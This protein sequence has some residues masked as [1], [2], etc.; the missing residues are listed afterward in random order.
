LS[1][2]GKSQKMD[3]WWRKHFDLLAEC[4]MN[5]KVIEDIVNKN[6]ARFR[7]GVLDFLDFLYNE[8]IPLI[9]MSAGPGQL[10]EKVLEKEGRLYNNIHIIANH[11]IFDEEGIAIGRRDPPI[12]TFNKK[13]FV[14][15]D[16]PIY[17]DLL[18]R[19]NVLL[20]GDAIGDID[21]V[22]GF[23]Y[24]KLVKVGF[25]NE[26]IEENLEEYRKNFDVVITEDG[27]FEFINKLLEE[28]VN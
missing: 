6:K 2:E 8:G 28:I 15:K 1:L 7:E 26:K 9:I 17:E 11:F 22:E 27:S 25:L 12:H 21:M 16:L 19:K 20:L 24:E 13:E 5:K 18:E 10:I 23:A 4:G 14:L 3:E